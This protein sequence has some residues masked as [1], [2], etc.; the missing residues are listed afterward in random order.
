MFVCNDCGRVTQ[1][2]DVLFCHHC[3]STN[4]NVV[5]GRDV[6][7]GFQPIG[8]SD[9]SIAYVDSEELRM[10]PISLILAFVPGLMN[11]FGIGHLVIRK[12]FK[13]SLFI[14]ATVIL[15]Y[16]LYMTD[17]G[18]NNL[19]LHITTLVIFIVQMLDLYISYKKMLNDGI[20]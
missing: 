20:R 14:T 17:L 5:D 3:G 19:V 16:M 1:D 9:G 8:T 12:W 15:N 10:I 11:V 4:G 2:D 7:D 13:G 18:Q 6:P